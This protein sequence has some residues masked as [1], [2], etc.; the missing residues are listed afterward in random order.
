MVLKYCF[1]NNSGE[2]LIPESAVKAL[3]EVFLP[4]IVAFFETE[5]GREEFAKWMAEKV[6]HSKTADNA[7]NICPEDK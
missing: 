7:E 5:E 2:I 3:A 4:D 6:E 1:A